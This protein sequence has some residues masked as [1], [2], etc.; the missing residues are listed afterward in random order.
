MDNIFY[1]K[2]NKLNYAGAAVILVKNGE[3]HLHKRCI[4]AIQLTNEQGIHITSAYPTELIALI[5]AAH[6][7]K[8]VK[9]QQVWTDCESLINLI[10]AGKK[11]Q[12]PLEQEYG[13]LVKHYRKLA[14]ELKL[15]AFLNHVKAHEGEKL[16]EHER[17]EE[18]NG[19][20]LADLIA[21]GNVQ[22]V[23]NLCTNITHYRLEFSDFIE[24]DLKQ[25]FELHFVK[26]NR[27]LLEAVKTCMKEQIMEQYIDN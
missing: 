25:F 2:N 26:H 1:R 9:P 4:I 6:L 17:T 24:T 19:N 15:L 11:Q 8:A 23:N 18:Q 16:P 13:V 20:H 5:V 3:E 14:K 21:G 12:K 22:E 7:A 10:K 27:V